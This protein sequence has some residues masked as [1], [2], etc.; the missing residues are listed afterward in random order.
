MDLTSD[1]LPGRAPPEGDAGVGNIPGKSVSR[2]WSPGLQSV[3]GFCF[4]NPLHDHSGREQLLKF[5]WEDDTTCHRTINDPEDEHTLKRIWKKCCHL[6]IRNSET[7]AL[8]VPGHRRAV[9]K[10]CI[11]HS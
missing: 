6:K 3:H 7:N 2:N 1:S 11:F 10:L 8:A 4:Q 9:H 5:L